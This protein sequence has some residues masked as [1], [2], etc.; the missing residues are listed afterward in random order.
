MIRLVCSYLPLG[1]G[2]VTARRPALLP[3]LPLRVPR[4]PTGPARSLPTTSSSHPI[5]ERTTYPLL[6]PLSSYLSLTFL[7]MAYHIQ[8]NRPTFD[9]VSS[10]LA[11]ARALDPAR[12]SLTRFPL[13]LLCSYV[14]MTFERL[15]T[16]TKVVAV[17]KAEAGDEQVGLALPMIISSQ[18]VATVCNPPRVSATAGVYRYPRLLFVRRLLPPQS[19]RNPYP[20]ADACPSLP[21]IQTGVASLG[22]G[23]EPNLPA[24]PH[25]QSRTPSSCPSF[26]T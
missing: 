5:L 18:G 17:V 22:P 24:L 3:P 14:Q 19:T 13:L 25:R 21:S 15:A 23:M 9:R 26:G 4:A 10:P 20:R 6:A 16:G 2:S 7:D 1:V 11:R 12:P 8:A